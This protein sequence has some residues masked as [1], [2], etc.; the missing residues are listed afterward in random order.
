MNR[1]M[2]KLVHSTYTV[3]TVKR[4]YIILLILFWFYCILC[5]NN[6]YMQSVPPC[7][8]HS[9][10]NGNPWIHWSRTG[11]G[12]FRCLRGAEPAMDTFSWWSEQQKAVQSSRSVWHFS[13]ELC[14]GQTGSSDSL[15]AQSVAAEQEPC[16]SCP[17]LCQ[18]RATSSPAHRGGQGL[19]GR[20]AAA[21]L[22]LPVP[23]GLVQAPA[24][25]RPQ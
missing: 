2:R 1:N 15:S 23:R 6:L 19:H 16:A 12:G 17:Q 9:T 25:K 5:K 22:N 8:L 3:R 13:E 10:H 11:S 18:Q 24:G 14:P 21:R 7:F 20:A 4:G